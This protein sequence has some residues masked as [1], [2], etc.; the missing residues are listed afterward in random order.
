MRKQDDD[1][2]AAWPK[3]RALAQHAIQ[4]IKQQG[5]LDEAEVLCLAHA[6]QTL[7]ERG[8]NQLMPHW[9]AIVDDLES[10]QAGCS[11]ALDD[12]QAESDAAQR[13]GGV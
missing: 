5:A 11:D 6:I 2:A 9:A 3:C 13:M 7:V 10:L 8:G 1:T 4:I 12:E